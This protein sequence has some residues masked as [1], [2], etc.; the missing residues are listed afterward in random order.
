[1]KRKKFFY[2]LGMC[3][4]LTI[5]LGVFFNSTRIETPPQGKSYQAIFGPN[6]DLAD[7]NAF[8][9][10]TAESEAFDILR[11]ES[12][13][14]IDSTVNSAGR[15]IT[16]L[17]NTKSA[18]TSAVILQLSPDQDRSN[19][20]VVE[21]LDNFAVHFDVSA[22]SEKGANT[23]ASERSNNA[24]AAVFH[25]YKDKQSGQVRRRTKYVIEQT[26]G[27][28][29]KITVRLIEEDIPSASN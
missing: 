12:S 16:S 24:I 4:A 13:L 26:P 10:W 22:D 17:L 28:G 25:E 27:V 8:L 29:G 23:N 15:E 11:N 9:I 6:S 1:M 7:I 5:L 18:S 21:S 2:L 20:E 14:E 19:N 3:G